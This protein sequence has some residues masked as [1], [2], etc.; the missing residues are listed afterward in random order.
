MKSLG[1][2]S[3]GHD[4][5]VA[6]I[7]DSEILFAGHAERY[8]RTKNDG[9]INSPLLEDMFQ[10]GTP[11][12]IIWYEKPFLKKTR[13]AYAGQ[14]D[15]LKGD[16]PKD[17]L[18]SWAA[19]EQIPIKYV[20]HHES[21][22]AGGYY[23]SPFN[24]ASILVCDAIG[25]WDCISIWQAE[26]PHM[27][28]VWSQRYPHSLGLLYSAMTQRCGLK[29]NEEE[30]ILM[31]MAALGNRDRFFDE[32]IFEFFESDNPPDFKLRHNVHR[33][34]R[35][36]KP[37]LQS[38]QDFYDI[39][40]SMQRVVELYMKLTAR[41]IRKNLPSKNLVLSGGVALN[42][43]ANSVIAEEGLFENIWIMPNPGDAGS[44]IGAVAAYMNEKLNW[45]GPYLGTDI[46][47]PF[48][49]DGA[50]QALI[51]GQVIGVANGRAE[52]GP[53]ALGNRS[54]IADPRGADVKDKVNMIKK[55]EMFRPF[56]PVVLEHLADQYFE[57]PQKSTPYM[58]FTAKCKRPDL[59]PAICHF[60]NTSRVQTLTY[61]QNPQFYKLIETFYEKTGCPIVLNTSL[62]IKGQPLVNTWQDALMFQNHYGVNVF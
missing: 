38:Q 32:I 45:H 23:T 53:R 13:F 44:S 10:Y 60:D 31:G 22:A 35:W 18:R 59:L 26:G 17:H 4:A 16:S 48:D 51:D 11:D 1:V 15:G 14:W 52:Y 8:S 5:S 29:P 41:W 58:Q 28:K 12:Q 27:K 62:N 36:W 49:M 3:L 61:D 30:Y 46:K 50:V 39:A 56:A 19:L 6:L 20:G 21:H 43:V 42:C 34:I 25:E 33:G 57:M 9:N 24:D 7:D 55:R 40:A 2:V 37:E 54:L 47:R